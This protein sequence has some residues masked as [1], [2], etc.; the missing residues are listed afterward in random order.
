MKRAVG[1]LLAWGLYWAGHLV[2]RFNQR[3]DRLSSYRLY[4]DLM[5]ASL[6]VQ[7]WGGD[8]GPWAPPGRRD[9]A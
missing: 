8:F 1:W 7:V 5:I 4:S 3:F 2:S 9:Y 6:A